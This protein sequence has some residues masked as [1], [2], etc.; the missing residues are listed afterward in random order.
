AKLSEAKLSAASAGV[1]ISVAAVAGIAEAFESERSIMSSPEDL[2]KDFE[3]LKTHKVV[4]DNKKVPHTNLED[5]DFGVVIQNDETVLP[6][7]SLE[8]DEHVESLDEG[9]TTTEPEGECG[10]TPE[11]PESKGKINGDANEKFEDEGT[12]LEESSEAGDYEDKGESDEGDGQEYPVGRKGKHYSTG[13]GNDRCEGGETHLKVSAHKSVHDESHLTGTESEAASDEEN[14]NEPLE[15]YTATSGH[16]QFTTNIYSSVSVP[17]GQ[18]PKPRGFMNDETMSPSQ[19]FIRFAGPALM[20]T[21]ERRKI[22]SLPDSPVS[23]HS[24]SDAT[25]GKDYQASASTISPA[26]LLEEDRYC[27]QFAADIVSPKEK[28]VEHNLPLGMPEKMA[29]NST[30]LSPA[31]LS[32]QI[33]TPTSDCS[34]N[35]DLTP[36][37]VAAAVESQSECTHY[38]SY[39][40]SLADEKASRV[41][42]ETARRLQGDIKVEVASV[43]KGFPA[44]GHSASAL[45]KE[46]HNTKR[47]SEEKSDGLMKT[48]RDLSPVDSNLFGVHKED[49][50]MSISEGTTSDKSATPVDEV[51]A[52]DT[53]SHIAS[54]STAS[55]ATSSLPEP[56]ADDVSPSLHAEVGSPQ[57]TEV[58]DSLSVSVVQTPTTFQETEMSPS[59]EECPRPMSISPDYSPK[60]AKST[61]PQQEP[62][63][64]EQ[65]TMSVEFS[66]ESPDH[67]LALDFSKQSPEHLAL[68]ANFH[69]AENGPTEVDF[70][71]P[72]KAGSGFVKGNIEKT[73]LFKDTDSTNAASVSPSDGSTPSINTPSQT[74]SP[75][76]CDPLLK[77]TVPSE[78][79]LM[80]VGSSQNNGS[81][82]GMKSTQNEWSS[83]Q[84]LSEVNQKSAHASGVPND[85]K[86]CLPPQSRS[87]VDLCL[88][89]SCE[90]RHPKTELSPSFINPNPLEYF[91]NEANAE[92]EEKPF[93][94]CGGRPPSGGKQHAKQCEE[95]PATSISESAPSQTDSDVPPGT[96]E[97]PSITADG[98]IDSEDDSETL[99]TDRTIT[100]RHADP[101]PASIRDSVPSPPRPD[102]CMVDP[103]AMPATESLE[104]LSKKEVSDKIAKKKSSSPA[105]KTTTAKKKY[106]SKLDV[107]SDVKGGG[108]K[109]VK[110]A[111]NTY[112]SKGPKSVTSGSASSKA[113]GGAGVPNCPP[114]Y[115]DLVYVPNHCN[116][117]NVDADFFKRVRSSYYVVSGNDLAA[118]EPSRA[119]LDS[120]LEGKSQWGNNMQVT[121]IPTHDSVVMREWYQETHEKQQ[122]LNITVLAS[123]STVVMQDESFPA[124]KIEL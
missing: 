124:C 26:S 107:K 79:T 9:I 48:T 102:V 73:M 69:I 116:A 86:K 43:I 114:V 74:A 35:S 39:Y 57:S 49:S 113:A 52:E 12:G 78:M 68:G 75:V 92:E 51:V 45:D 5:K 40:E 122:N 105:R 66:Q 37:A 14:C 91:A 80:V 123:S 85:S 65:A 50:K 61:M 109:D 104:N 72:D 11:E 59:R 71:P 77:A 15:E 20:S 25:E 118:Q 120:L 58:D 3:E 47:S 10:E 99:P 33:K 30:K 119:V 27:K 96:E 84:K 95:T 38:A 34:V 97:C 54:A 36:T 67:S 88:V 31:P 83:Y 81:Q 82:Q 44:Y 103:E 21:Y 56:T 64:P 108:D 32:P 94:K 24:K 42:S 18:M 17:M 93:A 62:K 117:K 22:S 100:H 23:D 60:T 89:T 19:E 87:N 76:K 70:S 121:L 13:N 110:N 101:P 16:T 28:A 112:A 111:T 63:S 46:S 115:L 4:E 1:A 53:F 55:L 2:T 98:N 6:K 7:E 8:A 41:P 29:A 106:P 90:Y